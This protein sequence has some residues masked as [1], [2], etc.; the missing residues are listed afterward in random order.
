MLQKTIL[1]FGV[2][3]P[4]EMEITLGAEVKTIRSL[5]ILL[6]T[7]DP[8]GWRRKAEPEAHQ[9]SVK[10][11]EATNKDICNVIYV[12][13]LPFNLMKSLIFEKALCQLSLWKRLSTSN[14]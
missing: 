11:T 1:D 13:G 8:S 12:E 6:S 14:I 4:P 9:G 5:G 10:N 3:R 7:K 2:F